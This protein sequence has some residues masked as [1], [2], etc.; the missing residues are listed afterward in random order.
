MYDLSWMLRL[1]EGSEVINGVCDSGGGEDGLLEVECEAV[2][3][4]LVLSDWRLRI[5]GLKSH[6]WKNDL[7]KK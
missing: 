4:E 7:H 6:A 2:P 1:L 3:A 5:S